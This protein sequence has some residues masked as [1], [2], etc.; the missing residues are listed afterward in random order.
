[1]PLVSEVTM[2]KV[3]VMI[4]LIFATFAVTALPAFCQRIDNKNLSKKVPAF[5]MASV[6][7]SQIL[8]RLAKTYR[9]PIGLEAIAEPKLKNSERLISVNL[10]NGTVRDVLN[11]VVEADT[12][13]T[14]VDRDNVINIFPKGKKNPILETILKNF[15]VSQVNREEALELLKRMPDIR[16]KLREERVRLRDFRS[17]PGEGLT[18]S[19]RFSLNLHNASVR[20]ILNEITKASGGSYWIFFIYGDRDE[21]VSV[22]LS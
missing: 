9:V 2:G 5:E 17:F 13:Y 3:R 20:T 11:R 10:S 1:M 14:W 16:A 6:V 15:S 19:R 4:V 8:D 21:F 18:S 12:R 7:P 22:R